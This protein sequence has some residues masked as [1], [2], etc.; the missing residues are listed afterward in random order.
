MKNNLYE[1]SEMELENVIEDATKALREK[2]EAKRKETIAK[3]KSLAASIG[4]DVEISE[5]AKDQGKKNSKVPV[6]YQNPDNPSQTWSGRGMKPKWLQGLIDEGHQ[7][8]SF[9]LKS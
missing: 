9:K 1:L 4:V 6:K 5:S 8:E 2:K 7:L 3:I